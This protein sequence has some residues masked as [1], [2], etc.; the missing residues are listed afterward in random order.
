MRR[1]S[2]TSQKRS[3][4]I[5]IYLQKNL[6]QMKKLIFALAVLISA[7]TVF[8]QSIIERNYDRFLD[9]ED[10][11]HVFVSG[12]MFDFASVIASESE[13]E[14]VKELS[15]FASKIKSFSLIKVPNNEN[16]MALYKTGLSDI[17]GDYEEL[18]R[19]RDGQTRFGIFVD[20]E[21]DVVYEVV[22]LGVVDGEFVALSLLGEMDLNK[23]SEFVA[24]A[25]SDV[26]EPL[27]RMSEYGPSDLKV[28]P[29]PIQASNPLTIEVPE[30][31]VGGN[32][33]IYSADGTAVKKHLINGSKDNISTSQLAA[34]NY[35]IEFKTDK[36]TMKKSFIVI[37]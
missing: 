31:L 34:G 7:N 12:K 35:I 15:D 10:V 23:I 8:S 3:F 2:N 17:G 19:I 36:V 20:E 24:Q 26:F 9:Q 16:A 29:N 22:G 37:K 6:I 18:M 28:Y 25:D 13:D 14:Q 4:D 1:L 30:G 21:D 5:L 33:T 27:K 11:T 32:A